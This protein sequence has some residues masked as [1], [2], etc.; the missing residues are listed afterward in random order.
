MVT[1]VK[2]IGIIINLQKEIPTDYITSIINWL[3]EHN[4]DVMIPVEIKNK[5]NSISKSYETKYI[6]ENTDLVIVFGGDGTI[7][8][9][10][11]EASVFSTPILGVNMGHL[12]FMTDVEVKDT[13][14]ALESLI[15]GNYE[16][17][18]R[19][20]LKIEIINT[21]NNVIKNTFHCLNEVGIS[22]GTL[23]K[24]LTLKIC[25]NNEYFDSYHADGLLIS[26]PT[27]ST[28]YSLSAGGP[29]INPKINA[30]L[31]TP[32]CPHSLSARSL[33]VSE[34]E[35]VETRIIN[36]YHDA[37]VTIDGQIG[38]SIEP[39]DSIIVKKSEFVTKLIKISN[40]SFYDVLRTKLKERFI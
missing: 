1:R 31:I 5:V 35:V 32:L 14:D 7:L 30:V 16:I 4:C 6:Y 22:R 33:I 17:E 20:M 39:E 9:N 3:K 19:M 38:Y 37:Y 2:K 12:G 36:S 34:N 21:T 11:R 23:S 13:F 18:E 28:A 15:N 27:G 29:I 8:G 24:M 10:A 40:R 26:T 25:I